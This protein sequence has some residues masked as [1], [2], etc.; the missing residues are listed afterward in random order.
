MVPQAYAAQRGEEVAMIMVRENKI[1]LPKNDPLRLSLDAMKE[2]GQIRVE[3][4]EIAKSQGVLEEFIPKTEETLQKIEKRLKEK[5]ELLSDPD[6]AKIVFGARED[7]GALAEAKLGILSRKEQLE[8]YFNKL[9][10]IKRTLESHLLAQD[11]ES[12]ADGEN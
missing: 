1:E 5:P 4:E 2:L 3:L 11:Q 10:Q 12:E 9:E 8:K 6:V 7:A